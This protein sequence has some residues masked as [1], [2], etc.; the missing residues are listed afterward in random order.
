MKS[1]ITSVLIL[2]S[3]IAFSQNSDTDYVRA[4]Y[5]KKEIYVTMR[6]GVRLF[7]SI[8]LPK[9][10]T[11]KY[12]IMMQRTPYSVAP[13]GDGK[14]KNSLGPSPELHGAP[15]S[16]GTVLCQGWLRRPEPRSSSED[17]DPLPRALS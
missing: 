9:D 2:Y 11:K 17:P 14:I 12:P 1:L 10:S 15:V 3:F 6:D 4:N 5:Q 7:T 13:Y 16:P 8:Y